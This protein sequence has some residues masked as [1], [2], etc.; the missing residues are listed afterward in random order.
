MFREISYT[1]WWV[2][3][4]DAERRTPCASSEIISRCKISLQLIATALIGKRNKQAKEIA[5][6]SLQNGY[7]D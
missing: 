5:E 7:K 6:A 2:V 3:V 4:R 1:L